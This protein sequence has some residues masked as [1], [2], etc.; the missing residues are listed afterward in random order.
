MKNQRRELSDEDIN[1]LKL[2]NI[3]EDINEQITL[4]DV[5]KEQDKLVVRPEDNLKL[6]KLLFSETQANTYEE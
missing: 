3:N 5:T 6:N 2:I 4:R 1:E